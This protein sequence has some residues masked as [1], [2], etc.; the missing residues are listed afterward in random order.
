[1]ENIFWSFTANLMI[2]LKCALEKKQMTCTFITVFN[3]L[4]EVYCTFCKDIQLYITVKIIQCTVIIWAWLQELLPPPI[5]TCDIP[6]P[7]F[8][9]W[10]HHVWLKLASSILSSP[11][12]G[13]DLSNDSQI[14]E[15]DSSVKPEICT[16]MLR[17]L[18]EISSEQNCLP[19]LHVATL[20]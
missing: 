3:I 2:E 16:E 1:M 10:S 18:S 19:Q 14:R 15:I 12:E 8:H 11:V 5:T 4:G 20:W 9:F 17:N 7:L 6:Q 13:K